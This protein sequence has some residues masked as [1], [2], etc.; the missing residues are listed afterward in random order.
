MN[1]PTEPTGPPS[2]K[3]MF[4]AVRADKEK[5]YGMAKAAKHKEDLLRYAQSIARE[6]AKA[7]PSH[8][9]TADDVQMV[10]VARGR[11]PDELGPAAGSLFRN[12]HQW[13]FTGRY[14][15]ST[16]VSNHSRMLRVWKLVA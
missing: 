3:E 2:Q 7:R 13:R 6:I 10:L 5:E 12:S 14:V 1:E 9:I 15:K 16:R 4:D 11:K 8:E